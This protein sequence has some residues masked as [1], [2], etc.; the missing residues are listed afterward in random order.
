MIHGS[1]HSASRVLRAAFLSLVLVGAAAAAQLTV[2]SKTFAESRLLAEMMAQLIEARTEHTVDRRLGLGGTKICHE[3]I[4]SGEIDLY[5]EY[6][7]TGW[8]IQ[9]ARQERIRDPTR[10]F[11]LVSRAYRKKWDLE[12]LMPFGFNNTYAMAMREDAAERLGVKRVSQLGPHL[13]E[14]KVGVSHEFLNRQD[15]FQGLAETY[16]FA[17]PSGLR[18]ME[19]GL[20]YEGLRSGTVDL[21]DAYSTDG[22]LLR[23]KV[24]ILEDD[25]G[26]FPPYHAAPVVRGAVLREHPEVREVLETLGFRLSD[27]RMRRLNYKVEVE[28]GSFAAVAREFLGQEK[29]LED[30]D[31]EDTRRRGRRGFVEFFLARRGE[32]LGETV[33]HLVLTAVAVVLAILF[34]VPLGLFLT[35]QEAL[36]PAVLGLTGVIQTIPSLAMLA[37]MIPIP[38]LGLGARSAVAALF[39]YALL[40]IL[41]N[42]YT[43][44]REVDAPLIEAATG[45]GLR[46]REI[47]LRIELPLATRTIMAGIRTA[48]VISVGVATLAGFVGAGGLG[49]PIITGLQLN[50]TRLILSGAIPAALLALAV[51]F[52]LG[53]LEDWLTPAG[54]DSPESS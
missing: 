28:G 17:I 40:P 20:A 6:T 39:L 27:D 50:D 46:D 54:L 37:F 4:L 41:R 45:M 48:S 15:G 10:T 16:G 3:A 43:G 12:W 8:A 47:L 32:T 53:R 36:A 1:S 25:L 13:A 18:G 11:L 38:G 23:Y 34:A 9:L 5:A 30:V 22:K 51:D 24:S 2:G 26:F 35:R 21:V 33:E 7:G 31:P 29:L 14:L 42:T 49:D 44:I 19:H 52:L